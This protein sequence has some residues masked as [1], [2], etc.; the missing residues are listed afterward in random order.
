MTQ[1]YLKSII[2]CDFLTVLKNIHHNANIKGQTSPH[3][4][5]RA[6]V[7]PKLGTNKKSG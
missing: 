4:G 1:K 6:T 5:Y 3:W 7:L 2:F